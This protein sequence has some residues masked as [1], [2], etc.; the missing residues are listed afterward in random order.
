MEGAGEEGRQY[1]SDL[2]GVACK[3][4]ACAY[5]RCMSRAVRETR[6][7]GGGE[8]RVEDRACRR[9]WEAWEECCVAVTRRARRSQQP[10][11]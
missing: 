9:A 6:R 8:L 10:Q 5:Q 11:R 4:H 2:C 7:G 3:P 1:E